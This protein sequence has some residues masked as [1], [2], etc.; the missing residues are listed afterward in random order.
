[1]ETLLLFSV[2]VLIALL[3]APLLPG[4]TSRVKAIFAGRH[5]KPLLQLY[6][7]LAKLLR[8]GEVISSAATWAFSAGPAISLAS[9]L[10]ALLLLPLGGMP[11]PLSFTGDFLLFAYLLGMGRFATVLAAIDT[12][13]SFEG[14]GASR[15][16]FFGGITEPVLFLCFLAL[17]NTAS[18]M[19]LP[20]ELSLS[21]MFC[22]F[23]AHAWASGRPEL[24][25][26]A[27]VMGVILLVENCRIPVDDPTTHLELTMIHEVMVLDHSGI[28]LAFILYGSAL[29]L[30]I[31]ASLLAGLIIPGMSPVAHAVLTTASLCLIAAGVGVV[32]SVMAR[33]RMTIVPAFIGLAGAVAA[34]VL[35]LTLVR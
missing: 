5:G 13:S 23:S 30:W 25:L 21:S 6:Y 19:G 3:L 20:A 9:A 18:S 24:L 15:E 8:K 14:M 26:L 28:N 22:G 35:I 11:S 1:M 31:F 16:A 33:L 12:G 4:I 34:F 27:F 29:K 17:V 10:L 2:Q 7:D 32:E